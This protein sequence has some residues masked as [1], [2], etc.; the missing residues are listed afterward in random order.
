MATKPFANAPHHS[1]AILSDYLLGI[2]AGDALDATGLPQ[3]KYVKASELRAFMREG[4]ASVYNYLGELS[5]LPEIAAVGDVFYAGT[6]FTEDDVT[7]TEGHLYAFT[8][9]NT[10]DDITDLFSQYAKQ[11]EVTAIDGRL[12]TAE[13][14]IAA[15]S[16]GITP[17]GDI[18]STNLPEASAE[19]KGW[20]YYCTDLNKYAI[21]DGTQ[22]VY[23]SN[24]LLAD[25]PST[26]DTSHALSNAAATTALNAESSTRATEDAAIKARLENLEQKAGDYTVTQYRG[27]NTVP[28]G[29]AKYGLVGSIVGK[30]RPWNMLIPDNKIHVTFTVAQDIT[31]EQWGASFMACSSLL[32][33]VGHKVLAF[34]T[35]HSDKFYI[36]YGNNASVFTTG[37][38]YDYGDPLAGIYELT[39][40]LVGNGG[41]LYVRYRAGLLAGTYSC[42]IY[43]RDLT[44][45]FGAGNEPS[46]VAECVQKCP[47]ILKADSYGFS[48]VDT[49]VEGV[50]S[51]AR[52]LWD[53]QAEAGTISSS[54]G[55]D[56][57]NASRMRSVGYIEI[58]SKTLYFYNGSNTRIELFFYDADKNFCGIDDINYGS[59][60]TPPSGARFMRF[61]TYTAYGSTYKG[62][63][64]INVS[65]SL[66]GT[67]TPYWSP[68]T[69]SL[70]TP[71]TLRSAGSVAEVYDLESGEKS[72]PLKTETF[73]GTE[74]WLEYSGA[75]TGYNGARVTLS[76]EATGRT[77]IVNNRGFIPQASPSGST[78]KGITTISSTLSVTFPA[79]EY[80][81]WSDFVASL[82]SNP[83]V[84]T[85]ALATPLAPTQLTPVIDN[86]I[87]TEGGGTVETIQ[88]QT[89]VIDNSLDVGYL[90]LGA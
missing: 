15:I 83:L 14:Q 35:S 48:M 57:P 89:P 65:D 63:I 54:T 74:G 50:R 43:L 70:P 28:T 79:T 22:W 84:V 62:D 3:M 52:N 42:D 75:G 30:S 49:T 55:A 59:T 80:A 53:E 73:N 61:S 76:A 33:Y 12:A 90:A 78:I 45:I 38:G 56:T 51:K 21:S 44:L 1:G 17:K 71:I 88:T 66:N 23:F 67:Y 29:K 86:T 34:R 4:M 25:T 87:L 60:F 8:N 2:Q 46:T 13:S 39:N 41:Y 9:D 20:Q 10:W 68:V 27:T 26:T 82:S 32:P 7:Y 37:N 16:G 11:A 19:N 47:D 58:P 72:N 81:T 69:L 36:A 64:C 31:S 18:L 77:N 40:T 5:A 6:T 85:Y 24:N